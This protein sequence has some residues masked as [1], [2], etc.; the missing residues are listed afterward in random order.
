MI[1]LSIK[2]YRDSKNSNID[3]KNALT[4]GLFEILLIIAYD[5]KNIESRER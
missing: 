1:P 2:I 4:K 5:M 3:R